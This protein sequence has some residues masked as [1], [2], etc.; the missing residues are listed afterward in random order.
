M[1]CKNCGKSK[2]NKKGNKMSK[3]VTGTVVKAVSGGTSSA[4]ASKTKTAASPTTAK[5]K[6]VLGGPFGIFRLSFKDGGSVQKPN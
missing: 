6:K 5:G 3:K 2:N 4:S 1:S